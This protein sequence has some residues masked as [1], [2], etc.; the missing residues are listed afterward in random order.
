M[1]LL[2]VEFLLLLIFQIYNVFGSI[3]Y[4]SCVV[5]IGEKFNT[6]ATAINDIYHFIL[7]STPCEKLNFSKEEECIWPNPSNGNMEWTVLTEDKFNNYVIN[8]YWNKYIESENNNDFDLKNVLANIAKEK[9]DS[10]TNP[11]TFIMNKS[12]SV[13]LGK[14]CPVYDLTNKIF[15]IYKETQ[16][17][18]ENVKNNILNSIKNLIKSMTNQE[19]IELLASMNELPEEVNFV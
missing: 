9:V 10:L 3:V 11:S 6:K 15:D 14:L 2:L 17:D 5:E 1:I 16:I 18:K 19:K 7:F 4:K 8:K 13:E 12:L